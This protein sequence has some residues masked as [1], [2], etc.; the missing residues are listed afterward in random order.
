MQLKI[1]IAL[2]VLLIGSATWDWYNMSG[3]EALKSLIPRLENEQ[4]ISVL[5]G[6]DVNMGR[7]I[8]QKI[9]AGDINYPF[10]KISPTLKEADITFVNLESQL[11]D[12]GGETQ[13]PTNEFR[14]A[15]PPE[16]A[17]SLANA[18]IDIVSLANNHMWDYGQERLF[19]TMNHL[20][21]AGIAYV[22]A[23]KNPEQKWTPNIME[24]KGHKVGWLAMTTLLNGY[25]KTGADEYVAFDDIEKLQQSIAD[26]R[27]QVD[28][29]LV[30][31]HT[32]NEY[33]TAPEKETIALMRGIIDAGADAVIGHH[34]HVPRPIEV[35][36]NKPIFYSLG[37]FAFW[38]PF[39]FATQHSFL[40]RLT[41]D[42]KEG[43]NYEIVP[44]KAGWQPELLTNENL[45]DQLNK[46]LNTKL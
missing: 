41:L 37:N 43:L 23:S 15:G 25:E 45:I 5:V 9:L 40:A 12:L 7:Q 44:V 35:Y 13:S 26:L 14:F 32:G 33:Q 27:P 38:Q 42:K 24:I 3:G 31:V 1:F 39:S 4:A 29:V 17:Q 16:S 11:A 19:E 2:V 36:N 28:W 10:A 18:G 21:T 8:G 6:G 20:E 34:P 30:S 46:I 22:G